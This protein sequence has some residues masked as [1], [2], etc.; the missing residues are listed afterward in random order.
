MSQFA[1]QMKQAWAGLSKK[2]GF[3][4]TVVTTMGT[5]LGAL[6]CILTLAYLLLFK[7]L[8]YPEQEQLYK[9]EHAVSDATGD[10]NARAYT[11]PGLIHLYKNQDVFETAALVQ[12][13]EDVLTSQ[14]SQPRLNMGYVTP[15]WFAMLDAK[16]QL[17]RLFEQTEALDTNNPVAVLSD[18]MWRKYTCFCEKIAASY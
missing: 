1:Y 16:P 18:Q 8:P 6:L 14:P 9:V 15:E 4:A 2:P 11:Y 3:V 10:V 13:D 17:G 12:Y 7:P 5:T